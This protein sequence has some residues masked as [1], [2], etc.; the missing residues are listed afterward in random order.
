MRINL[1]FLSTI[2]G[3]QIQTNPNK[4]RKPIGKNQKLQKIEYFWKCLDVI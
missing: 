2:K 3:A 4:N 1:E